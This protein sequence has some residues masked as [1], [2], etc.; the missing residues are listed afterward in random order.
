MSI[1]YQA[2]GTTIFCDDI[3]A[4]VG[5]K[6]T[7][8][9]IYTSGMKV[10]GT[11]PFVL[12]K[13][14]LWINYFEAPGRTEDGKLNVFLPGDEETAS[15]EADVPLNEMRANADLT[16]TPDDPDIKIRV[17]L[18]MPMIFSPLVLK[19]IGRIRVRLTVGETIVRMGALKIEQGQIPE[20]IS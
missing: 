7:L 1:P 14:A 3:R 18:Q 4:E 16:K 2:W 13:F 5:G 15:I 11:F 20:N 12:P 17:R 6:I 9:G 19:S 8:I 10:H